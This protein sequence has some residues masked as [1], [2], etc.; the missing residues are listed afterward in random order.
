MAWV[1]P[2]TLQEV[3]SNNQSGDNYRYHRA[4]TCIS[5]QAIHSKAILAHVS[6]YNCHNVRETMGC[7]LIANVC[8]GHKQQNSAMKRT[9]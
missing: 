4:H 8:V 9:V 6:T 5:S 1:H 7:E 3:E 2:K